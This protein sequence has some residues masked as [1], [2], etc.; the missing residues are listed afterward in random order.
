MC[1]AKFCFGCTAR[2][3][4]YPSRNFIDIVDMVSK[5]KLP[6]SCNRTPSMT[7]LSSSVPP[8]SMLQK[9]DDDYIELT[10]SSLHEVSLI[11]RKSQLD[12]WEHICDLDTSFCQLVNLLFM[13]HHCLLFL[14]FSPSAHL[15][16]I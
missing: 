16:T 3:L 10:D 2:Q 1:G 14:D 7:Q 15:K 9:F 11:K 13:I 5:A 12:S 6:R 4:I 8:D